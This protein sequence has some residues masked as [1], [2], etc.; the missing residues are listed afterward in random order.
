M[1]RSGEL[2]V[3]EFEPVTPAKKRVGYLIVATVLAW[4][5]FD[6]RQFLAGYVIQG[7]EHCRPWLDWAWANPLL[8]LAGV[9]GA[10]LGW[11]LFEMAGN[12]AKIA[13]QSE[14]GPPNT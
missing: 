11:K 4:T 1:P 6:N 3:R 2:R 8:A 5:F 10:I 7:Y 14:K 13:K 9:G 12:I